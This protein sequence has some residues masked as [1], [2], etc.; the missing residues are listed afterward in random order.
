MTTSGPALYFDGRT[1]ARLAA[2]AELGAQ[3]LQ[4]RSPS[5]DLLAEWPY[6]ELG[7][8]SAP[9]G[10]LRLGRPRS[11]D[12]ARLEIR[13]SGLAI[14]FGQRAGAVRRVGEVDRRSRAKVVGWSFAALVSA[15]LVAI[16]GVPAIVARLTP[17]VPAR[18]EQRLGA[19]VDQQ[20]RLLLDPGTRPFECGTA[21]H[22]G[23]VAFDK[24]VHELEAAAALPF[25][26]RASV[27]RR[28]EANAIALPGG[29]VYVFQGLV[30]KANNPD[31]LAGAI[32]HEMGH[33]AQRDGVRV[34]MQAAGLSFLFGM[35]IGDFSGGGVAVIAMRTVLQSSYSRET[36]A[37][38]DGYGAALLG[39]LGRDPH[40]LGV[41]L[42]RIA[43]T[44]GPMAKILLD[45]PEAEE[46]AAA[47]DALARAAPP[48]PGGTD[49]AT[50]LDDS[51]WAALKRI[52]TTAP[53]QG[54][55][56]KQ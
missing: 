7:I 34:L 8:F 15:V 9:E 18:L 28:P 47:I 30:A 25:P 20:V 1:S 42:I 3:S 46:R 35:L 5:G 24:L 49:A 2:T 31:E 43:G 36:E 29:R 11:P 40:A 41:I 45:H 53:Q 19:S 56:G 21:A 12:A 6:A 55:L 39:R 26:V 23:R 14:G 52:C 33:V 27:I 44:P 38:A 48:R 32:A 10:V 54:V 13:D 51:E 17:L 22:A 16:F 37:A 50:L 4:I